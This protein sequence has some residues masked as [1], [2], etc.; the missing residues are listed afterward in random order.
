MSSIIELVTYFF[1]LYLYKQ[2][3]GK[4]MITKICIFILVMAILN[5]IREGFRFGTS[6]YMS[7]PYETSITRTLF[8]WASISYIVTLIITGI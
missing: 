3:I 1:Y 5:L 7:E 4:N 2:K 8:T 6:F